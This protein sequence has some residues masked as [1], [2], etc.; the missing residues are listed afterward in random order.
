MDEGM[1][2]VSIHVSVCFLRDRASSSQSI[3]TDFF[4]EQLIMTYQRGNVVKNAVIKKPFRPR[5]RFLQMYKPPDLV[6]DAPVIF[7][8]SDRPRVLIASA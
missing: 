6:C 8:I 7:L 3:T 1:H 5:L 4:D 2:A